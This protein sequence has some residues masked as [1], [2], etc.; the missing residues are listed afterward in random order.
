MINIINILAA[1]IPSMLDSFIFYI[2]LRKYKGKNSFSKSDLFT[3]LLSSAIIVFI[4]YTVD[5]FP[6]ATILAVNI[7]WFSWTVSLKNINK[8]KEI[9]FQQLLITTIILLVESFSLFPA[10]IFFD[11]SIHSLFSNNVHSL[12]TVIICK[13]VIFTVIKHTSSIK[14]EH[15]VKNSKYYLS[16][17]FLLIIYIVSIYIITLDIFNLD[18]TFKNLTLSAS[19]IILF[20]NFVILALLNFI[21][22]FSNRYEHLSIIEDNYEL[23]KHI[24]A[25]QKHS[26]DTIRKIQHEYRN[27]LSTINALLINDDIDE[28]KD[29]LTKI[30]NISSDVTNSIKSTSFFHIIVNY[31]FLEAESKDIKTSH[32]INIPRDIPI[33]DYDIGLILNNALNNAIEACLNVDIASRYIKCKIFTKGNYLN[34]Y[35][36]NSCDNNFEENN[37]E[38]ITTKKDKNS[39]GFRIKNIISIVKKYNGL[40]KYNFFEGKYILKLSLLIPKKP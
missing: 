20:I 4:T 22:S 25:E 3:I 40:V 28:A 18:Y 32:S 8:H 35:F 12:I 24:I 33:D 31:K 37:G 36:E 11:L 15:L 29:M 6:P 39:H 2:Y 13:C 34:F 21:M 1:L 27:N 19:F 30:L 5:F 9:L 17:S 10:Q 14:I 7:F 23:Q 26:I 16:T 38:L